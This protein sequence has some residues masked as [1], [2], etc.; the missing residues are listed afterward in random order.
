MN[1]QPGKQPAKGGISKAIP[2]ASPQT[3]LNSLAGQVQ[4]L[5]TRLESLRA[6]G[7]G[8][9]AEFKQLEAM[10]TMVQDKLLLAESK[11]K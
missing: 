1:K 7:A 4:A 11:V 8:D 6:Q 9:T 2:N 5:A 10:L 3:Q